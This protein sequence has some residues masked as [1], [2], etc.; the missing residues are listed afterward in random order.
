MLHHIGTTF[1]E[2]S[3]L[4]CPPTT[5]GFSN[6]V[7]SRQLIIDNTSPDVDAALRLVFFEK[8]E[9]KIFI[10]L[11]MAVLMAED[12]ISCEGSFIRKQKFKFGSIIQGNHSL[13]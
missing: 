4:V 8:S 10:D 11:Q 9:S 2:V 5:G 13:S 7:W 1:V 6:S 3:L 12:T